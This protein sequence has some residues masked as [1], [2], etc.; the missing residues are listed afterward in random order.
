MIVFMISE[1]P[2]KIGWTRLAALATDRL[3]AHAAVTAVRLDIATQDLPGLPPQADAHAVRLAHSD[4]PGH[5]VSTVVMTPGTRD[6][7]AFLRVCGIARREPW[8][9]GPI[10]RGIAAIEED[11]R[12]RC[13]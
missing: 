4:L 12:N 7:W 11:E 5:G 2:P 10:Q 8:N 9:G 1:V 3:F 13:V 6:R